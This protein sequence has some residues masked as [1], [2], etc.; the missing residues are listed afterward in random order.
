[1]GIG[2]H[3]SFVFFLVP[4]DRLSWLFVSFLA[5]VNTVYRIVNISSLHEYEY[6]RQSFRAKQVVGESVVNG[7]ENTDVRLD[8]RGASERR[9]ASAPTGSLSNGP[10]SVVTE[11]S[12]VTESWP[13]TARTTSQHHDVDR[14]PPSDADTRPATYLGATTTATSLSVADP[15]SS[16]S[17]NSGRTTQTSAESPLST[18]AIA[19]HL[20]PIGLGLGL[21]LGSSLRS[22]LCPRQRSLVS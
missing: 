15:S 1:M 21:G 22:R 18:S 6:V 4:C 9:R 2:P 13:P 10:T 16:S 19:R 7:T 5:H 3:S 8:R 12:V 11:C 17:Q 20:R 14:Q